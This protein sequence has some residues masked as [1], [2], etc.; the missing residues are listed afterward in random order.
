MQ[1]IILLYVGGG[2]FYFEDNN[3]SP[4]QKKALDALALCISE[5]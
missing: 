3:F 2:M 5:E 4:E 1:A